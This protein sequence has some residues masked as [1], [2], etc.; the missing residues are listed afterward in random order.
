MVIKW[1]FSHAKACWRG[2]RRW[3]FS[4]GRCVPWNHNRASQLLSLPLDNGTQASSPIAHRTE[5]PRC[6]PQPPGPVAT[7]WWALS[8]PSVGLSPRNGGPFPAQWW[9]HSHHGLSNYAITH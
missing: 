1:A 4:H 3:A 6:Y 2:A 7:Q 5:R 9:S 8:R